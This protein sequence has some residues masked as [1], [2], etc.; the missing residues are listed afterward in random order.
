MMHGYLLYF[1]FVFNLCVVFPYD[2]TSC[3]LCSDWSV[4]STQLI[5]ELSIQAEG[6]PADA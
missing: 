5:H 3:I 6:D 4:W 1:V 2:A